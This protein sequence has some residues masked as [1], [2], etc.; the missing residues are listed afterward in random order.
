M[1]EM[2]NHIF[3]IPRITYSKLVAGLT[4]R[5]IDDSAFIQINEPT[6]NGQPFSLPLTNTIPIQPS[7][8]NILNLWFDDAEEDLPLLNGEKLVLFNEEMA[9]QIHEFVKSNLQAKAWFLHCTAGQSR[10]GAVGDVLSEYFQIPYSDFK[11]HNPQVK[12]NCLV[13]N[14]LRKKFFYENPD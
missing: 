2:K 9:D 5:Q 1:G 7:N 10:S 11:Y 6:R 4:P 8:R 14:L 3:V 13:K 12:P